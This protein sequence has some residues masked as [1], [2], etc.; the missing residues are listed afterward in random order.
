M[1]C[2]CMVECHAHSN[3]RYIQPYLHRAFYPLIVFYGMRLILYRVARIHKTGIFAPI[4]NR[5]RRHVHLRYKTK[6]LLVR[7]LV[8]QSKQCVSSSFWQL[9]RERNDKK[10]LH[11]KKNPSYKTIFYLF[12]PL[13]W[14]QIKTKLK[15]IDRIKSL[16]IVLHVKFGG[17]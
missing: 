6:T 12:K 5:C 7:E 11:G 14:K 4:L 17:K 10:E 3:R 1:S 2:A 9:Q 13:Y 16:E 15:E 8:K